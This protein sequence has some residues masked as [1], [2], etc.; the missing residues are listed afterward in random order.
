MRLSEPFSARSTGRFLRSN[1]ERRNLRVS[2]TG[3]ARV[4][5]RL[6]ALPA[7]GCENVEPERVIGAGAEAGGR[8]LET[9]R[10]GWLVLDAR[11]RRNTLENKSRTVILGSDKDSGR[12]DSN[13]R[14][15]A[16]KAI[17]NDSL[18][19][20]KALCLQNHIT[21]QY[22]RKSTHPIAL[23]SVQSRYDRG[24]SGNYRYA[25]EASLATKSLV[26]CRVG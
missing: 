15:P 22:F 24:A 17:R 19:S 2:P 6:P 4:A 10:M 25:R 26:S 5:A 21:S 1:R 7:C 14:L 12:Q 16:P 8:E 18:N 9:R 23:D 3:A 13:L 20:H 11:H